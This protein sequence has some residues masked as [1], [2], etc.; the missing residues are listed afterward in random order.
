MRNLRIASHIHHRLDLSDTPKTASSCQVRAIAFDPRE[1]TDIYSATVSGSITSSDVIDID[2]WRLWPRQ[3][4]VAA[5]SAPIYTPWQTSQ[6]IVS[7]DFLSDGGSFV[8][9]EPALCVISAGGDIAVCPIHD[10]DDESSEPTLPEIVGSVEQ[11]ILAASWSPDQELLVLITAPTS[12]ELSE[13]G[14]PKGSTLL[15]MT[16]EFEVLSENVLQTDDFGE[17]RPI[18]LG[19]G[20]K[21]TQFHGSEGKQAAAAA[22]VLAEKMSEM[23]ITES[24]RGP[25]LPDD[26]LKPRISWRGDSAVFSVSA[27]ESF[28]GGPSQHRIIRTYGKNAN[29]LATLDPN[30]IGVSHALAFKPSGILMA[31]TQVY[32]GQHSV[33]FIERNGLPKGSFALRSND[34]IRELAWNSDGSLLAVWTKRC[35]QIWSTGNY[36]WYLKQQFSLD[37]P[38]TNLRWHDEQPYSLYIASPT[39]AS[40]YQ[41]V[42]DTCV[43]TSQSPPNDAS[44]A[45]VV[46]GQNILLTPFRIQNIPPPMASMT[47]K[48]NERV[49]PVDVTWSSV[50]LSTK[51]AI[52][53]LHVLLPRGVVQTWLLQWGDLQSSSRGLDEKWKQPELL[54]TTDFGL[55]AR[56]LA[57]FAHCKGEKIKIAVGVLAVD[58][59]ESLKLATR[60]IQWKDRILGNV[61]FE[62]LSLGR[63]ARRMLIA[64]P[65]DIQ[66][67][68]DVVVAQNVYVH[69]EKLIRN[70]SGER[71]P[72]P[73]FFPH[74]NLICAQN[75]PE[76]DVHLVG[77]TEAG[78]LFLNTKLL[79]RDA[80]SFTLTDSHIIWTNVSHEAK[81]LPIQSALAAIDAEAIEAGAAEAV[82]LNRRVERGSRIVT[83]V[84]SAMTLILQMP[85]GNLETVSPRPLV[86]EVVRKSLQAQRYGKAFRI[87]RTHRLD[88]NIIVDHDEQKFLQD[89]SLFVKQVKDGEHLNLFLSSLSTV[90]TKQ[91]A[92]ASKPLSRVVGRVSDA[93]LNGSL[94][95]TEKQVR[96]NAICDAVREVLEKEDARAYVNTILTTH[97][98]KSPPDYD[99]ALNLLGELKR[100]DA[101]L[102]DEACKYVIFLT[103]ADKLFKAALGTYDFTLPLLV[104]H[105]SPRK[106]PREYLPFL[107]ELREVKPLEMQ[108]FRVDE[109]LERWERALTWLVK[110]GDERWDEA[111]EFI[112]KHELYLPAL[113]EYATQPQRLSSVQEMY[114][115]WLMEKHRYKEAG[116]LFAQCRQLRKAIDADVKAGNWR[117]ALA[118]AHTTVKEKAEMHKLAQRVASSLSSYGRNTEAALIALDYLED[119]EEGVRLL[120]KDFEFG[121]A[122]RIAAKYGR[123]EELIEGVIRPLVLESAESLLEEI[124]EIEDQGTKQFARLQELRIRKRERPEDYY[125]DVGEDGFGGD[126]M[127]NLDSASQAFTMFTR[128]T[129][130]SAFTNNATAAANRRR[131]GDAETGS[132]MSQFTLRTK[133]GAASTTQTAKS[134]KKEMRKQGTGKKNSIYEEDYLYTSLRKLLDSRFEKIQKDSGKVLLQLVRLADH[135]PE[136]GDENNK[137]CAERAQELANVLDRVETTMNTLSEDLWQDNLDDE[138]A[139]EEERVKAIQEGLALGL[140]WD[141]LQSNGLFAPPLH[142]ERITVASQEWRQPAIVPV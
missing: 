131:R 95:G 86:L 1:E 113:Q 44:C 140:S 122:K 96:I 111:V 128:F 26:D 25:P 42:L 115:D 125:P 100:E 35:I 7:L 133:A 77:L 37:S 112:E 30:V 139:L 46:D 81:F 54:C 124:R 23:N 45:A 52:S 64:S 38:V 108:R 12:A 63:S 11:G 60:K 129:R 127:D 123:A 3:K 6:Q 97:V 107:R 120:C 68:K 55:S 65:Q 73:A 69:E 90:S 31:T 118:A 24:P 10:D 27:V 4:H 66:T 117:E 41:F 40:A 99:A 14:K 47:I 28:E 126:G 136:E 119:V 76:E 83:A 70:I 17:E 43:S 48:L 80:N 134:R 56:Q 33:A 36:H 74:I 87:C 15:L 5:F 75:S 79:A 104:A 21:A 82:P 106:D 51:E 72:L 93:R 105:H 130:Y 116:I 135:V 92:S 2:L 58:G 132:T 110:A 22:A 98:R 61:R 88:M 101:A 19:W 53:F 142:R 29:L 138:E 67:A 91:T 50:S 32:E 16:R 34:P 9:G 8:Q 94:E 20:S 62:S 103:D 109:T 121:E 18:A 114:G 102:A 89:V 78:Q 84:P 49:V 13:N 141:Q 39:G 71:I 59:F 137:Q 57:A 85:R